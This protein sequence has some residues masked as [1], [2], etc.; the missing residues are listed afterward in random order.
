MLQNIFPYNI[1]PPLLY[2][3][4]E[5][6]RRKKRKKRKKNKNSTV[7]VSEFVY[8]DAIDMEPP[9]QFCDN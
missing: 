2:L 1:K 6:G 4:Y 9:V 8:Y 7:Y 3:I 5:Q